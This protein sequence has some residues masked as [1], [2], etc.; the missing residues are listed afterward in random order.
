VSF[1][2]QI[3]R[4]R[5][6]V[7]VDVFSDQ[8]HHNQVLSGLHVIANTG[9]DIAGQLNGAD[10][11]RFLLGIFSVNSALRRR[12]TSV[13]REGVEDLRKFDH[14]RCGKTGNDVT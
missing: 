9:S 13:G 2:K 1:A 6:E 5:G 12:V 14:E 4:F 11:I 8:G 3:K 10:N 7:T